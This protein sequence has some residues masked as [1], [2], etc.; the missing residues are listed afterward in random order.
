MR[1]R[2]FQS[3]VRVAAGV[4]LA[5]VADPSRGQDPV[6]LGGISFVE[7]GGTAGPITLGAP[8][9]S[10]GVIDYDNDGFYDL[11]FATQPGQPH[12]LYQNVPGLGVPGGRAF[13]ERTVQSGLAADTDGIARGDGGVV[14]LDYDNDGWSDIFTVAVNPGFEEEQADA[15]LLY[16]N[17]GDGTFAN[18]SV[19]AGVRVAG[20]NPLS[21]TAADFDHDGHVDLTLVS[22]G[23]PGRPIVLLRNNGDGTFTDRPDLL[24]PLAFGGITYASAWNDYDHDGWEDYLVCFNAGRPLLLKNVPDG[25]GGRRFMDATTAS[26]FTFVGPAPM[27]IAL[28]DINNDGWLDISITDALVG[29]YY[30]NRNGTFVRTTPFTTFFGWGTTWLDADNDGNLDNYQAGSFGRSNVDRLHRNEGGGVFTDVRAALNTTSLPSQ[31][32]AR[33][34]FDNDGRE[35]IVTI[36]PLSSVNVH[37]NQSPS[38]HH[39]ARVRLVGAGDVARD[40]AGARV[41]LSA[42]GTTRTRELALG[43][44]FSAGEDPRLHF[45][46]G[47]A[48]QIDSI[49]VI[50]PRPGPLARR[51]EVFAGPFPADTQ[52]TLSPRALC[53]ADYTPDGVLNP[54]DLGDFITDYFARPPQPGPGG[55]AAPC[56]ANPSP[57]HAGYRA[58]YTLDDAGQCTEPFSDNLGDYITAY[59]AGGC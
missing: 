40:A 55:Y 58:A 25:A 13:V 36:N 33:L 30:E 42:G 48:T 52:I 22:N 51:T 54:D 7:R 3:A 1:T 56:S 10:L 32:C 23:T 18:V 46:L 26:G 45:G 50:W 8:R 4:V 11:F 57:Y 41:L 49:T 15:G 34:D 37:H 20:I 9:G 12:R 39:W 21:T 28:G 43:T 19:A 29:T 14:I 16:R 17:N 31:Y 24:P 6:V 5:T 44:S 53:L 59:F 35:D 2:Y 27:G 47:G 38:G